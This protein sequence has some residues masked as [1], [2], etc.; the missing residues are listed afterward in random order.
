MYIEES[1][2]IHLIEGK[3]YNSH[4][5]NNRN[6]RPLL[7]TNLK[8]FLHHYVYSLFVPLANDSNGINVSLNYLNKFV[9][10]NNV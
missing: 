5:N 10:A 8:C 1:K 9:Y 3:F 2:K 7:Y 4:F 6:E